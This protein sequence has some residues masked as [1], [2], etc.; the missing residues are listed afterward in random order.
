M[1]KI[2]LGAKPSLFPMPVLLVGTVV[3]GKPNFLVVSWSGIVSGNPPT[4]SI[5]LWTQ[6][7]SAPAIIANGAFSVNI[8]SAG[9]VEVTD[10]CG[11]FSGKE[12]DK[13]SL[14]QVFYGDLKTAP[15]IAE[16]P[17]NME[18]KVNWSKENKDAEE[19]LIFGEI[20]EVWCD[21]QH[22]TGG[23]PDITKLDPILFSISQD[24]YWRLGGL[25]GKSFD[26]GKGY[27]K[28]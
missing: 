16:C 6:H 3:E 27:G 18:C 9:M 13:S 22:M 10:Y 4:I 17:L 23:G 5:S 19:V 12:V 14:F 20:V 25:I 21:E 1:D 24:S 26:I 7:L 28:K 8:P 15:M 11:S 2:K